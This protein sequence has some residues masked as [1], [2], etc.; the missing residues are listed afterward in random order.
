MQLKIMDALEKNATPEETLHVLN[1]KAG[2]DPWT[3]M[4]LL[5]PLV[6]DRQCPSNAPSPF[7][8]RCTA[9][10]HG[11]K[12]QC[13][14]SATWLYE[15]PLRHHFPSWWNG[16]AANSFLRRWWH[17]HLLLYRFPCTKPCVGWRCWRSPRRDCND[18]MIYVTFQWECGNTWTDCLRKNW[19]E[20]FCALS[21]TL[22]T[23]QLHCTNQSVHSVK[24]WPCRIGRLTSILFACFWR[25]CTGHQLWWEVF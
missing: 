21:C 12:A 15:C 8:A 5:L 25:I 3:V 18:S 11:W 20:I 9:S 22:G 6:S 16:K 19:R 14:V 23:N 17:H 24:L 4:M 2:C 10:L 7:L 13:F 1:Q